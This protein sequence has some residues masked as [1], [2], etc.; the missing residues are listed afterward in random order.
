MIHV[1]RRNYPYLEEVNDG[2]LR[3]FASFAGAKGRVL[4]VGCGRGALGQAIRGKGWE[5]WGIEL[6]AE[7][8]ATAQTRLD[9]LIAA[10]LTDREAVARQI[11][12][13]KFDILVFADVLEHLYDPRTVLECYLPYVNPG[14]KVLVS[15]PNAVVWSN[16]IQWLLGRV[17]YDDTGVMDRTH[18]RFFS[19]N[20]ARTLVEAAGCR[21]I[22]T[23]F[24]PYLVRAALPWIK[25]CAGRDPNGGPAAPRALIDS[26]GY[27]FYKRFI[28]PL[29]RVIAGLWKRMAA[30][31]IVIVAEKPVS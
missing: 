17:N 18:L 25:R 31:Q 15:V 30:F 5:V 19:F 3:Q 2:I 6:N 23:D 13:A 12:D 28:Y 20:S 9:R 27:H 11:G 29:E 1:G 4:D 14:G 22:K 8:C 26:K 16:R 24:T 7:A 21:V 10:D